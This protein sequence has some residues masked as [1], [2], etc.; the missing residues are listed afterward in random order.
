VRFLPEYDNL[1]LAHKDRSRVIADE[2]RPKVFLIGGRV[3]ATFLVDGFVAGIW[4]VE[5]AKAGATL[6][7]EPF[8]RLARDAR[9]ALKAE[10]ERLLAFLEEDAAGGTVR[11]AKPT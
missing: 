6:V 9:A 1:V 7:L 11:I 10:G 2:H 8:G 4:K 3:R 5:A